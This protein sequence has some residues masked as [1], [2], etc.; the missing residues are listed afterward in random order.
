MSI[1]ERSEILTQLHKAHAELCVVFER[2][3]RTRAVSVGVFVLTAQNAVKEAIDEFR[4]QT[5]LPHEV[6]HRS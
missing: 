5:P 6:G 2:C 3:Q 4:E 1:I